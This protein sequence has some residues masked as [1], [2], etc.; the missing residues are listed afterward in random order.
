M[1]QRKNFRSSPIFSSPTLLNKNT[2]DAFVQ[3]QFELKHSQIP[4]RS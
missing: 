4:V 3:S 2:K 1:R